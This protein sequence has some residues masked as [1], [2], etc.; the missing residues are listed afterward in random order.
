[1]Y[2]MEYQSN[3]YIQRLY[4][5][6]DAVHYFYFSSRPVTMRCHTTAGLAFSEYYAVM[7]SN[8]TH[9]LL[10]SCYIGL[11]YAK[12]RVFLLEHKYYFPET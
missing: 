5:E 11:Q 7:G 9:Q 12:P 6:C 1:M 3:R 4:L 2:E 8:E 10:Q